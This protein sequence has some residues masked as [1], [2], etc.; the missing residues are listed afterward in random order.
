ME[1]DTNG[2]FSII[3]DQISVTYKKMERNNMTQ[4][5]IVNSLADWIHTSTHMGIKYLLACHIIVA[6]FVQ[7]CEVFHAIAK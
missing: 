2:E 4:D 3:A 1:A 6:F 5:E 7:N